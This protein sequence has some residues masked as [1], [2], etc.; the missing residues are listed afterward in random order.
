[1]II[2]DKFKN[3]IKDTFYDKRIEI[4]LTKELVDD[5]GSI[6]QEGKRTKIDEFDGNFQFSSREFIQQEYGR[7]IQASAIV[8]CDKTIAKEG[9]ILVYS[10]MKPSNWL[11]SRYSN[12]EL[13][14]YSNLYLQKEIA[15]R[16]YIVKS[17][18]PGDSHFTILVERKDANV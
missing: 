18:I 1:M 5:E 14:Q 15:E 8:T 11:L 9:D 16:E 7:D 3:V 2:P 13:S 6:V 4:W 12:Q 10:D 17:V